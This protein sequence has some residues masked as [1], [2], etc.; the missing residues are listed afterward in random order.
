MCT[1]RS[2]DDIVVCD[3]A[4][5]SVRE[6]FTGA[7]DV[8]FQHLPG[9]GTLVSNRAPAQRREFRRRVGAG[10][11]PHGGSLPSIPPS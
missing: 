8:T 7:T 5:T 2:P 6:A 4:I 11:A 10:I 3:T 9:E 1:Q